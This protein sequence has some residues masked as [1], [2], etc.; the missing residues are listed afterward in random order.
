MSL[1]R[2]HLVLNERPRYEA[3]LVKIDSI[4]YALHIKKRSQF[5]PGP[6]CCSAPLATPQV[7]PLTA[8]RLVLTS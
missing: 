8:S 2:W 4:G 1:D 5:S 6:A 3:F 7:Q